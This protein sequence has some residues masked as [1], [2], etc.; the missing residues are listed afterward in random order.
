MQTLEQQVKEKLN[1]MSIEIRPCRNCQ[2]EI[3]FMKTHN[4]KIMPVTLGLESHFIDCP[5]AKQFRRKNYERQDNYS[6]SE[7]SQYPRDYGFK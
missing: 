5:G 7:R 2:R 3:I 6:Q 1:K 4:G